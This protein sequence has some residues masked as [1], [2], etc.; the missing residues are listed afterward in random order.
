MKYLKLK[1]YGYGYISSLCL[2][3]IVVTTFFLGKY[4]ALVNPWIYLPVLVVWFVILVVL[5]DLMQKWDKKRS[6]YEKGIKGEDFIEGVLKNLPPSYRYKRT[7][8]LKDR[9]KEHDLDFLVVGENGV[10]GLEVK[11]MNGYISYDNDNRCLMK[12][13]YDSNKYLKQIRKNCLQVNKIIKDKININHFIIPILVF[14]KKGAMIGPM[15]S[16]INVL[17]SN[18]LIDFL[19]H[20]QGYKLEPRQQRDILDI[21]VK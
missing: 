10:F 12:N 13:G 21:F 2:S 16:D 7:I 15:P 9:G 8:K 20:Y 11:N 4:L 18:Q 5:T 19:V 17:N 3:V 14:S 1:S 6:D